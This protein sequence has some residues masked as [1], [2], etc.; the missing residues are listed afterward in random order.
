MQKIKHWTNLYAKWIFFL[1]S[2]N[3]DTYTGRILK[4]NREKGKE[5]KLKNKNNF[6]KRQQK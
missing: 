2:T 1:S 3:L 6:K 4:M 5:K